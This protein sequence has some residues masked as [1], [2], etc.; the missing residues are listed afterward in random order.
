MG[1]TLKSVLGWLNLQLNISGGIKNGEELD[2][3][4]TVSIFIFKKED[5]LDTLDVGNNIRDITVLGSSNILWDVFK[6]I[7]ALL[8]N[9]VELLSKLSISNSDELNNFFLLFIWSEVFVD[10]TKGSV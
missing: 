8:N 9:F 7:G 6:M 5:V 3:Q 10:A 2:F 4:V 1:T